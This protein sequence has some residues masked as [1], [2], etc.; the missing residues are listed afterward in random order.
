MA[1]KKAKKKSARKL[2]PKKDFDQPVRRPRQA[3]LPGTEDA[4]IEGLNALAEDYAEIRDKR[5]SLLKEEVGLKETISST[6]HKHGKTTYRY[7]KV[8][9]QLTTEREKV[10]VKILKKDAE[11]EAEELEVEVE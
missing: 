9:I 3:R 7:G 5:M 8:F 1:T 10:R 4:A 2:D 6:M 11:D